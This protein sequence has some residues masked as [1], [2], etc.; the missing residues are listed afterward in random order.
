MVQWMQKNGHAL[1]AQVFRGATCGGN[2][3]MLKWLCDEKRCDQDSQALTLAA[4]LPFEH[5][6]MAP[7][8]RIFLGPCNIFLCSPGW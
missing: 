8:E 6:Q 2:I 4:P 5:G 1:T 3:P 7:C